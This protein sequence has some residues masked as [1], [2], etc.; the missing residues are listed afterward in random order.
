MSDIKP[1]RVARES[2]PSHAVIPPTE[3]AAA[4]AEAL[5]HPEVQKRLADIRADVIGNSPEQAAAF[6]REEKAR[7]GKVIRAA[8]IKAD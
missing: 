3:A 2:V 5:Q 1:K 6:I 7:W 4:V 8:N